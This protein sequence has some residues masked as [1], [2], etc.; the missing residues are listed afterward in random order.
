MSDYKLKLHPNWEDKIIYLHNIK[1]VK[2]KTKEF[3]KLKQS[4]PG[5]IKEIRKL[6]GQA[7]YIE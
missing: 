6:S 1:N 2:D 4:L 7:E 3:N 5:R